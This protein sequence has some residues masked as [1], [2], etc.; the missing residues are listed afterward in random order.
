M[1]IAILKSPQYRGFAKKGD[2]YLS[3]RGRRAARQAF[4]VTHG[5]YFAGRNRRP[6]RKAFDRQRSV[7][8]IAIA[9]K[10]ASSSGFS[11]SDF[12]RAV[13]ISCLPC[14]RARM[15]S[16][17]RLLSSDPFKWTRLATQRRL[18]RRARR[19]S[20]VSPTRLSIFWKTCECLSLKACKSRK[21]RTSSSAR[22][23]RKRLVRQQPSLG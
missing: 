20:T 15:F 12:S 13:I 8:P 23:S 6:G 21:N 16:G 2:G 7:C 11:G 18:W 5:Q 14:Q 10:F 22:L 4:A 17:T 1:K 9:W 19:C 3:Q